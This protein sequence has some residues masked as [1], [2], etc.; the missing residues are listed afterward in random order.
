MVNL[1]V[2]LTPSSFPS[3][4]PRGSGNTGSYNSGVT[5]AFYYEDGEDVLAEDN[6]SILLED[7]T[8]GD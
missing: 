3:T 6:G 8:D 1:G 5:D 2:T 7:G 4:L